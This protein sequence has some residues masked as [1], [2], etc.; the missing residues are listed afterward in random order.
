MIEMA[1]AKYTVGSVMRPGSSAWHEF[2][3]RHLYAV[4]SSLFF[5]ALRLFGP[6]YARKYPAD[7][8]GAANQLALWV[9][10][11]I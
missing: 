8:V 4:Q 7:V 5:E 3:R 11:Y 1:A 9:S 6:F 10:L 2:L